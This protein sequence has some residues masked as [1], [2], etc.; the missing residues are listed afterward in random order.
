MSRRSPSISLGAKAD[1]TDAL[2]SHNAGVFAHVFEA[3]S[4]VLKRAPGSLRQELASTVQQGE[5]G[6]A[7]SGGTRDLSKAMVDGSEPAR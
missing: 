7:M 1:H 5:N 6:A 2:P 3:D 4:R